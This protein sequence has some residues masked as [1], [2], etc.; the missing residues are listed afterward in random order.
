VSSVNSSLQVLR[1]VLRLALEWGVIDHGPRIKM[2]SGERHREHVVMPDEEARCLTAAPEPLASVAIIL[3]DTGLRPD[4][5]Y[6]LRWESISW[7]NG[8]NGTLLV[9]HGKTAAVRRVLPMTPRVRQ[10]LETHSNA[11]ELH[12]AGAGAP[13]ALPKAQR[14]FRNPSAAPQPSAGTPSDTDQHFA[15]S[16]LAAP[17]PT[18]CA[19]LRVSHFEGSVQSL[20]RSPTLRLRKK[21]VPIYLWIEWS[22]REDLNLRPP[23]PE[24]RERSLPERRRTTP[25]DTKKQ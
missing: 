20:S 6:R 12:K 23:G 13:Q 4:E 14:C 7:A 19:Q 2:L 22:G 1:R 5:C 21:Q 18:K 24:F 8:R 10:V 17:F 9:T 15:S 3:I 25:S 11:S 16:P